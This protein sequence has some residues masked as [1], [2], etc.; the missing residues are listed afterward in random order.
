MILLG[1]LCFYV[2]GFAS[3]MALMSAFKKAGRW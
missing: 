1:F 2:A 3:A